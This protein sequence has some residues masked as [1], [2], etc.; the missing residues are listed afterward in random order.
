MGILLIQRDTHPQA[1]SL[2]EERFERGDGVGVGGGNGEVADFAAGARR[3][4]VVM[5]GDGGEPC[6]LFARTHRP[7]AVEHY[8]GA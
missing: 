8:S 5:A 4:A 6:N 1:V 7:D 2:G 3:L